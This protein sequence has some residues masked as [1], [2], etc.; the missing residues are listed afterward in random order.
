MSEILTVLGDKRLLGASINTGG[1]DDGGCR[2]LVEVGLG[3]LGSITGSTTRSAL[4][5]SKV[6]LEAQSQV[7]GVGGSTLLGDRS[8]SA[9]RSC[10][11]GFTGLASCVGSVGSLAVVLEDVTDGVGDDVAVQ[12]LSLSELG[13]VDGLEGE[14]AES[15]TVERGAEFD[16]RVGA[17]AEVE[18][19][20]RGSR[21][22]L[23][24]GNMQSDDL[25]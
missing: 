12:S 13:L 23:K 1:E 25:E 3:L 5:D 16:G 4:D 8:L 2:A 24:N 20:R 17:G 11:R 15:A 9:E 21:N 14:L 19:G 7:E 18:V 10:E 6:G 22:F